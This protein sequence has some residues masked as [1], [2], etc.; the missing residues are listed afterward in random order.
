M[1]ATTPAVPIIANNTAERTPVFPVYARSPAAK[2]PAG[3]RNS[4]RLATSAG[5][6]GRRPRELSPAIPGTLL[7]VPG[8]FLHARGST[9]KTSAG[10]GGRQPAAHTSQMCQAAQKLL[11]SAAVLQMEKL[12]SWHQD[13]RFAFAMF[14]DAP[15]SGRRWRW[16]PHCWRAA[17]CLAEPP[18]LLR[19]CRHVHPSRPL[20]LPPPRRGAGRR[21]A[22]ACPCRRCRP[23]RVQRTADGGSASGRWASDDGR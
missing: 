2:C 5:C 10:D 20:R 3:G 11:Q 14:R 22:F 1:R 17:A 6:A 4:V 21:R 7:F 18:K 16:R 19:L 13:T 12:A 9:Q 8:T 23:D 15:H